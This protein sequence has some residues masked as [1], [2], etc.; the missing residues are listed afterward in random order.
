MTFCTPFFSLNLHLLSKLSLEYC[1]TQETGYLRFS[2]Q[3]NGDAKFSVLH[4]NCIHLGINMVC[5]KTATGHCTPHGIGRLPV[6]TRRL[7]IVALGISTLVE[8]YHWTGS[9][10][11]G[12]IM[13]LCGNLL[14]LRR[15]SKMKKIDVIKP[16]HT[17]WAT[18]HPLAE[19]LHDQPGGRR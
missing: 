2:I 10:L 6:R 17:Q 8:N 7:P 14:M 19:P 1:I 4:D 11:T 12:M 5:H 3:E 15:K 16:T 18:E 9:A 13:V